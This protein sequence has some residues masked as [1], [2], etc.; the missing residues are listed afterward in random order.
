MK[1]VH[2]LVDEDGAKTAVFIDLKKNPELWEDLY[3]TLTVKSRKNEPRES[4]ESVRRRLET[5]KKTRP[6]G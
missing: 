2:F 5:R 1:G 6:H 3:D 4:L